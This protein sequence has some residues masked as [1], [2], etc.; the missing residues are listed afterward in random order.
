M[1]IKR[2]KKITLYGLADEKKSVLAGL[3]KLGCLHL[4]PLKESEVSFHSE[5]SVTDATKEALAYLQSCPNKRRIVRTTDESVKHLVKQVLAN[6]HEMRQ[7]SDERDELIERINTVRPWGDFKLAPL[8]DR[9]NVH[10][11]FYKI[12]ESDIGVMHDLDYPFK[13]VHQDNKFCYVV[14]LSEEE[15][16]SE[17]IPVKRSHIGSHSLFELRA[18]KE[19]AEQRLDENQLERERLTRWLYVIDQAVARIEDGKSLR[20]ACSITLNADQMFLVS[21]WMPTDKE[22]EVTSFIK[23]LEI[24]ATIEEP[25]KGELPPSLVSH[26]KKTGG[27]SDAMLFFTTPD[28]R[29]WDPGTVLFFSFSLF[30]AMIMN[31]AMYSVIFGLIIVLLH[32]KMGLSKL[33]RRLR[34]LFYFMSVVGFVWGVLAGSYFGVEPENG[35]FWAT[36]HVINMNDYADMMK[37]S[38][39]IGSLHLFIANAVVAW[40]NRRTSNSLASLGWCSLIVGGTTLWLGYT[41]DLPTV[42]FKSIGPALMIT[43]ALF[44]LLF[45]SHRPV[46]GLK[47]ILLRIKDGVGS[48]WHITGAFGDILSYMRLFALG[49]AGAS[50]AMTFN[51]MAM[52]VLHSLPGVGVFFCIIIL[53]VGHLLNLLLSL[54]AAFVHGIRLNVIE[55]LKWALS[56][57]GYPFKP[58]KKLEE[59]N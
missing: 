34:G 3:Q 14:V 43:G 17:E 44:I 31:D 12:P 16:E 55:F 19:N 33:G 45:E 54:M 37:M 10:V 1:S 22:K 25:K 35:T 7:I 39:V 27:G 21:G 58:F 53:L 24:A 23:N 6:K 49:L 48:L 59:S 28:Y 8:E 41:N 30:F 29:A 38:V 20:D 47:N 32:K 40:N 46:D 56:G 4:I 36:L 9:D 52:Q 51:S 15:P 11:W 5:V 13:I 57:E 50:L 2:L 42:W 18:M 26:A